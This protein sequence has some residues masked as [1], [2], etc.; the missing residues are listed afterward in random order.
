MLSG[1]RLAWLCALLVLGC[2][3]RSRLLEVE[4]TAGGSGGSSG[5]GGSAAGSGFG[6]MLGGFGGMLGGAGGVAGC[7]PVDNGAPCA[8][9]A[10]VGC[11]AAFPRCAPVYDDTC[12]PSCIPTPVCG[13][14]VTWK[15][16]ECIDREDSDC[17]ASNGHCGLTPDWACKGGKADCSGQWDC[18][19]V[20]GCMAA[21]PAGCA[22]DGFCPPE[23]HA[24]S[25]GT[26]GPFCG[27]E[28][29]PP[30]CVNGGVPEISGG[31][32]TGYCIEPSVCGNVATTCPAQMPKGACGSPGLTCK[33][34]KCEYCTCQN[35]I[36]SCVTPP[37]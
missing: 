19:L 32:Y 14:C 5:S 20:P 10:E 29:P 13:D 11:L 34:G 30:P 35:G 37:C 15:F 26:C 8:A 2:G 33:Y 24:V 22:P 12:C 23:C 3:S 31:Q 9:L 17:A 28:L 18:K 6:G 16:H 25:A 7:E 1:M 27:P 4:G 36:W 21:A